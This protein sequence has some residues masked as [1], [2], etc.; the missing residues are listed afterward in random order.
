MTRSVEF[1]GATENVDFDA[2]AAHDRYVAL[3]PWQWAMGS[4]ATHLSPWILPSLV[5]S[6]GSEALSTPE[7]LMTTTTLSALS[8]ADS[9][10]RSLSDYTGVSADAFLQRNHLRRMGTSAQTEAPSGVGI[11]WRSY[12]HQ[13][14]GQA[15]IEVSATFAP[16][17]VIRTCA[18]GPDGL[19]QTVPARSA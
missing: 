15:P 5:P 13:K 17:G 11:D 9:F 3:T 10:A 12:P 18:A 2:T 6:Q 14:R 8:L 19:T 4:G 7:D 16:P 1:L